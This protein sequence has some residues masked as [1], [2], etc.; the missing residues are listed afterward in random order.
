MEMKMATE[1]KLSDYT[2]MSEK[3]FNEALNKVDWKVWEK[4]PKKAL[5]AAGVILLSG[6]SIKL[7]NSKEE[8]KVNS[9][10]TSNKI[11]YLVRQHNG[12]KIGTTDLK[13]V[14]GG[15]AH[16]CYNDHCIPN[17][18]RLARERKMAQESL[19]KARERFRLQDGE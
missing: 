3:E 18:T 1:R 7:V 10:A 8:V 12:S 14:V 5:K 9:N 2:K 6:V 15:R 19:D 13:K 17:P 11:L 16:W 4:N